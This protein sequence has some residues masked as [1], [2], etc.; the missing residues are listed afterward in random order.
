MGRI[1]D[2]GE[3][4]EVEVGIDLRG[5]DIGV[6]KQFLHSTKVATGFKHVTGE[7]VSQPVW[8]DA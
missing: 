2:L 7:G 4:L 8:M 1:V 5:T 6:A 3:M